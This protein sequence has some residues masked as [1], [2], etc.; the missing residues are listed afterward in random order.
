MQV[1][2][3]RAPVL[4]PFSEL[5]REWPRENLGAYLR[6]TDGR[7]DCQRVISESVPSAPFANAGPPGLQ[8][9]ST[10]VPASFSQ[11]YEARGRRL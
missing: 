6:Q 4:P 10:S 1:R 3:P 11:S 2:I 5:S 9:Y 7:A 8:F